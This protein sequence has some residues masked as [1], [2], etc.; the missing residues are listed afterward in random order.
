MKKHKQGDIL[1]IAQ[2]KEAYVDINTSRKRSLKGHLGLL[3]VNLGSNAKFENEIEF[4]NLKSLLTLNVPDWP[5][6]HKKSSMLDLGSENQSLNCNV[7]RMKLKTLIFSYGAQ[8][9]V[10]YEFCRIPPQKLF[11]IMFLI[12]VQDVFSPYSLR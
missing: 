11:R 12:Q 10:F 9:W 2:A 6:H 1:W 5:H 4:E 8:I 3:R 7:I